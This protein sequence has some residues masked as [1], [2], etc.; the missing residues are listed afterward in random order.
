[1]ITPQQLKKDFAAKGMTYRQWA[2]DNGYPE[3]AVYNVI[4]G[5]HKATRG[6]AHEIAVKLGLKDEVAA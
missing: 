5:V 6:R 4:A 3:F 2:K 1:M